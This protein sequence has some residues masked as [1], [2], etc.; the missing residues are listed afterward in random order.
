MKTE[1]NLKLLYSSPKDPRIEQDTA[2]IER[3][4]SR[5]AKKYRKRKDYL[6]NESKL[7]KAL[8]DY[9][10]LYEKSAGEKSLLYFFYKKELNSEDKYA[11]A[12]INKL[13]D[14]FTK[15]ANQLIFFE[16]ALGKIN[17]AQQ[18]KFLGSKRLIRYHYFLKQIFET[19]KYDLSEPEEKI[20][21]LKGL[22]SRGLWV[23]GVERV[24]NKQT[25][26]H[27]GKTL[28]ISEAMNLVSKIRSTKERRVLS[29]SVMNTLF[30]ISDFAESEIN[31]VYIDKKINDELRGFKEPYDAT[32]LSYENEAR[33]VLSLVDTVSKNFHLSN[34]FYKLKAKMLR[35]SHLEYADRTVGVGKA[36]QRFLFKDASKIV[37]EVFYDLDPR[38]GKIFD[39]FVQR[40]QIDVFPQKGKSGGAFCSGSV[41]LPTYVL[42]NHVSSLSSLLTL[43]HEMG[44]A[45]HTERSKE[46]RS[47]YQHYSTAVAETAS[48]FFESLVFDAMFDKLSDGEKTIA[49]HDKIQEDM[50][51]IFRQI[52]FFNFELGLHRLIREEGYASKKMIA[53]LLNKHMKQYLGP[54]VKLKENDGYFF[55]A[56]SHFRRFFYV[57]SYAYGQLISKELV[58]C[59]KEDERFV[60]KIDQFLRAG[61]SE[62]P[63]HIF[64]NI[65]IDTMQKGF[66]SK[67]LTSIERDIVQLETLIGKR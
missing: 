35:L 46:Q 38:Y 21:N 61:G 27:K 55:V 47:I 29:N 48:T 42:L 24:L 11:E 1:W 13:S 62:T 22:P 53:E 5:F 3:A 16:L 56:V 9:E 67:G 23:S 37:R 15:A 64:K 33:S 17:R 60:D 40:G 32:I 39:R 50:Q 18:K 31:A 25:V 43:A 45:I 14:R 44:H 65:G 6:V 63:E 41:G 54:I 28:P 51:T 49:L 12:M 34:R 52:S 30:S 20:L 10:K 7:Y 57:Y 19:S 2:S 4:Y 58:N 66:F 8:T 36:R 26:L 59:L